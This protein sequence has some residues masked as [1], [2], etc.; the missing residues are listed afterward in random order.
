[1][2]ETFSNLTLQQQTSFGNGCTFVPDFIFTADCRHHDF[3]YV[4]GG[5][6]KDKLKA[7]WDMCRYMWK[8]SYKWWHYVVT[9]IYWVGLTVL[10][11]PY[12]FFNWGRYLTLE[13]IL[14][15]DL[16]DKTLV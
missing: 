16:K 10:P 3:N 14:A 12:F 9:V 4:R 7:D 2:K 5:W 8:D 6:L 1:M 13:E 11:F 15:E